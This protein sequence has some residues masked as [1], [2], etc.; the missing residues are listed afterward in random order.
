MYNKYFNPRDQNKL[1]FLPDDYN[2]VNSNHHSIV[3]DIAIKKKSLSNVDII[4]YRDYIFNAF[5]KNKITF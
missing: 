1:I 5:D 2:P 4:L 3:I